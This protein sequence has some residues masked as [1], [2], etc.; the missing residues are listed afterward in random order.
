[1]GGF[2]K[3]QTSAGHGSEYAEALFEHVVNGTNFFTGQKGVRLDFLSLHRKVPVRHCC[4][5]ASHTVVE[6][7]EVECFFFSFSSAHM[8]SHRC[9]F[10][11]SAGF[12]F[13]FFSTSLSF[14]G[15]ARLRYLGKAQQLQKQRY[16]FV[17]VCVAFSC[18][19][20]MVWLPVFRIFNMHTC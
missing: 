5:N 7:P 9:H 2:Q 18:V 14:V 3:Q 10:N 12:L 8:V 4:R 11:H 13:L 1:M 19:Q 16:P 17:S 6:V 20:T 15:N